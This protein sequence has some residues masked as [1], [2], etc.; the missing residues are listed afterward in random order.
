MPTAGKQ[1]SKKEACQVML[2][3]TTKVVSLCMHAGLSQDASEEREW[4]S[5]FSA[6]KILNL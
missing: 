3:Q 4:K 2:D 5:F 1:L 6:Y